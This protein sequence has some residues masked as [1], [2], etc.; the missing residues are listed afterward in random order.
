ML[1]GKKSAHVFITQNG[2]WPAVSDK[3]EFRFFDCEGLVCTNPDY[4]ERNSARYRC[5]L[6]PM[7]SIW[8]G[9]ALVR[10]SAK[11]FG[12]PKTGP[13]VLMVSA[14]IASKN[15]AEGIEAVAESPAQLVVAGDGPLRDE[16]SKLANERLP[17]RF[18]QL[19][20]PQPRCRHCTAAP[21]LSCICPSI[22]HSV[23]FSSRHL[24]PACQFLPMICRGP[25]G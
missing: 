25:D 18:L 2:D 24:P 19:T 3:A 23:M 22:S 14:L 4:F 9:S 10:P 12:F 13:V 11:G 16:I 20:V 6:I 17:G 1:G 8:T 7:A 21:T 5:A 15:V